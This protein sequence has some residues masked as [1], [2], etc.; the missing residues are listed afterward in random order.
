MHTVLPN[1]HFKPFTVFIRIVAI[2]IINQSCWSAATNRGRPLFEGAFINF[3]AIPPGA[4]HKVV[5]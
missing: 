3:G 2:A 5:T 1:F 4:V